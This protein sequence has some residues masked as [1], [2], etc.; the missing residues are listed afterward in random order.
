MTKKLSFKEKA[1]YG[2][3]DLGNGFT[4]DLGQAYLLKFYTDVCGISGAAAGGVFL[5]SKIFD[6]FMDVLAGSYIDKR[7]ASKN[8]KYRPV[9]INSA[10]ILAALT[11][12]TFIF[13][14]VSV[15]GKL[16]YAYASYM[17]WGL[18]YSMVN[19]PYGSLAAAMTQDVNDR[20]QLAS[21]RQAGSLIA[22]LI[23]GVAFM[24]IVLLFNNSKIGFPVAAAIMGVLGIISHYTCY[25][26]TKENITP[27]ANEK[28]RTRDL[29]GALK[30]NKPLWILII[31]SLFTIS[32]YN[33]KIAMLVYFCEYNLNDVKLLAII[34]FIIIGSSILSIFA[35][36][37]MVKI[38]GKKQ[39]MLIGFGISITADII[40]FFIPS[41][42]ISFTILA[43]IA[44]I[45]ISIPNGIVWAL[46]SDIIDYGEWKTGKRAA[47]VTYA[48][49][50][51]SRKVAQSIS[52]FSAGLGLTLI[53]Y[54]PK[55][56]QSNTSLTGIKG[57]LLLY[58]VITIGIAAII[59]TLW[60][61]LTDD[62]CQEIVHEIAKRKQLSAN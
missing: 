14:D 31:M 29:L 59:I 11:I 37:Q 22:L 58:P 53:G 2:V 33:I 26:F 28:L 47:G 5:F 41:S 24:P 46:I 57:L 7:K 45:A 42:P 36:P 9:M 32:A 61:E 21:F 60:Y 16:I 54:V 3:G 1:A 62:R 8:G 19:I 51:F 6:A 17:I 15:Q 10:F 25:K 34:N 12:I 38:F 55:A 35:I 18:C 13:P 23:T 30:G 20:T 27:P 39:S 43:S 44:F 48:A 4:F 52:G 40:N 56:I 50:S 49:F